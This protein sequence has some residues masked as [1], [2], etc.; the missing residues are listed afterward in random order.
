MANKFYAAKSTITDIWDHDYACWEVWER[1]GRNRSRLCVVHCG[2][3]D[4][5]RKIATALNAAEVA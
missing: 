5:A 3:R 1:H 4:T 2:G